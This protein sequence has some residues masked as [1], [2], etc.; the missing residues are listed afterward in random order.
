MIGARPSPALIVGAHVKGFYMK[1]PDAA[2]IAVERW[3]FIVCNQTPSRPIDAQTDFDATFALGFCHGQ[4][5]GGQLE[6]L[7]R[8]AR[9]RHVIDEKSQT[10][11]WTTGDGAPLLR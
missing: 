7:W 9:G 5:R 4:D 6:V 8:V 1:A 11:E 3:P 2:I 10:V